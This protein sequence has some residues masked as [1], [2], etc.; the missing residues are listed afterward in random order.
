VVDLANT[1]GISAGLA[2]QIPRD[3]GHLRILRSSDLGL[4]QDIAAG[5][6]G[7]AI[8]SSVVVLLLFGLA[9]YLSR[10]YRWVT[11]LAIGGGLAAA[12]IAALI[13]REVVG[14]VVVNQLAASSAKDAGNAA[15]S[16]GTSLLVSI[17]TTV[18][19]Y[20]VVFMVAGWLGS[21]SRSS[22]A[23]RRFLTPILRDQVPALIG[24]FVA[25]ALIFVLLGLGDTRAVLTRL[26]LIGFAAFGLVYLRR[27]SITEFP[28]A[29]MPDVSDSLRDGMQSVR[30]WFGRRA[31]R[32][33]E[34]EDLRLERLERLAGL[35][36]R[37]ALS[38]E[39]FEAEKA[40]VLRGADSAG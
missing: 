5:I 26:F 25:V 7:L 4:A 1:L 23:T 32:P 19:V 2:D 29:E 28:Q 39:E 12:G 34:P 37:G 22:R 40:A 8:I 18:I 31:P 10:G 16:I 14:T 9:V 3:V 15:W 11:L 35:H 13:L 38:D 21:P 6:R 33:S 30:G 27:N 17:A 36:E 20:G 24:V